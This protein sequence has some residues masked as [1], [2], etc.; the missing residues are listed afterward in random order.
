MT[1]R[2]R[3][4]SRQAQHEI[5]DVA[6]AARPREATVEVRTTRVVCD[7]RVEALGG[8][9]AVVTT[10]DGR[11]IECR[12]A[13]AID[14]RWLAAALRVGP[15]DAE[16]SVGADGRGSVWAIFPGAEHADVVAPRLV[17]SAG[18]SLELTCGSSSVTLDQTGKVRVRGRDVGA[19][20]SR[21]ARLQ[22]GTVRIN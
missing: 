14:L 10:S 13:Q 15:V 2:P 9:F 21:V 20:G 8:N 22:G 1:A 19:R 16:L 12:C 5:L 7:G 18:E 4:R 6:A 17:L 3:R 11:R